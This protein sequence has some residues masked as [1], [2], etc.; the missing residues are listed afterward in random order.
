MSRPDLVANNL[1]SNWKLNL[2]QKNSSELN[3]FTHAPLRSMGLQMDFLSSSSFS[4]FFPPPTFCI[5]KCFISE[6]T[7]IIFY[8][9][10]FSN[11]FLVPFGCNVCP[12]MDIS[13]LPPTPL[14]HIQTGSTLGNPFVKRVSFF[15]L[16]PFFLLELE[17]AC[18]TL[19]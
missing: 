15:H 17:L 13:P 3:F 10:L 14:S 19:A 11:L 8:Q 16:V 12:Q 5:Y 2:F 7:S 9:N 6:N 18:S 4:S 1:P